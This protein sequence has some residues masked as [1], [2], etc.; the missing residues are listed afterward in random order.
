MTL[1]L[2]HIAL[3]A[4]LNQVFKRSSESACFF[5]SLRGIFF[6]TTRI[7][8]S[9]RVNANLGKVTIPVILREILHCVI[10]CCYDRLKHRG[11]LH[12]L[13]SHL[14]VAKNWRSSFLNL[15]RRSNGCACFSPGA[16]SKSASIRSSLKQRHNILG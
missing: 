16:A 14:C 1:G 13:L 12:Y 3:L 15:R 5:Q 6:A 2:V 11:S 10:F 9:I 4:S 8:T 7:N